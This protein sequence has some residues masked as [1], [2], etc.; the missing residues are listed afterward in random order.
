[1]DVIVVGGGIA[2]MTC[3]VGASAEGLRVLLLEREQVLGGRARSFT[4][5]ASSDVLPIGPHVFLDNYANVLALLDRLGTRERIVW[6]DFSHLTVMD[7]ARADE[8]RLDQLPAPLHFWP[9]LLRRPGASLPEIVRNLPALLFALQMDESDVLRLDAFGAVDVLRRLGAPEHSLSTLWSFIARSVLN[10]P[11]ERC[12]AGSLF[13]L[14]RFL[15]C[16][17]GPRFGHAD[18]G[19]G[20]VFAEAAAALIQRSGSAVRLGTRVQEILLPRGDLHVVRVADGRT[21]SA[22]NLVVALPAP[23]LL[24]ILPE[25]WIGSEPAFAGLSRFE[26]VPYVSV[27]LWLD[28]KVTE[29]RLWARAFRP[30][31]LGCDFYD[32]S[33]VYRGYRDRPSLIAAN[34]IHSQRVH[35]L[36]DDRI[37]AGIRRELCENIPAAREAR[38]VRQSVRRIPLAIH[39]PYPG[40]ERIRP[41]AAL[42][43]PGLF[44]AGDW[45][46]TSLPS[47]MESA[48]RSGWLAAEQVLLRCGRSRTLAH[49]VPAPEA[50]PALYARA[51]KR[52]RL[53]PVQR[54]IEGG[55]SLE[56]WRPG[57]AEHRHGR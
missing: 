38:V 41:K 44:L 31:D 3:A 32:L 9:A 52:L 29:R 28:R 43:I 45:T 48:A 26:A 21:L 54:L 14:C 16:R 13:R 22:K 11:L 23:A 17:R 4:E 42:S 19:L 50:I 56:S 18:R 8:G 2:G 1:L 27:F 51:A 7:G 57:Y 55:A 33:N 39:G 30:A 15:L 47:S 49:S 37:A 53:R 5:A 36:D 6:D 46:A 20:D 40:T 34:I 25:P 24:E 12:S 10:A 35:S